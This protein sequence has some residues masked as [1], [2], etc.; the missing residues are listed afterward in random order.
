MKH[1]TADFHVMEELT[2]TWVIMFTYTRG[3]HFKQKAE[4]PKDATESFW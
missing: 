4:Q 3:G 2:Q 1:L